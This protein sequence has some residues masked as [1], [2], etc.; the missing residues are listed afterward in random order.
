MLS[1]A[2]IPPIPSFPRKGGRGIV[3]STCTCKAPTTI[4]E[5][6]EF[7]AEVVYYNEA[8]PGLGE[9]FAAAVEEAAARAVDLLWCSARTTRR[10]NLRLTTRPSRSPRSSVVSLFPGSSS[11]SD[12]AGSVDSAARNQGQAARV[13]PAARRRNNALIS[14][15]LAGPPARARPSRCPGSTRGSRGPRRSVP[16]AQR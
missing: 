12:S 2:F 1:S 8:Q 3:F 13:R 16:C 14:S 11:W 10:S 9:R 6:P 5:G 4:P 15:A 7:L